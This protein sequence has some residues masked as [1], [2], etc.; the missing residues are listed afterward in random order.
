MT[1]RIITVAF[2]LQVA[3]TGIDGGAL[4]QNDTSTAPLMAQGTLAD[5]VLGQS[6]DTAFTEAGLDGGG[7]GSVN[8]LA[9]IGDYLFVGDQNNN[10][11]LG[12]NTATLTK[13]LSSADNGT[14]A[15]L[16]INQRDLVSTDYS[17]LPLDHQFTPRTLASDPENRLYV[18]TTDNEVFVYNDPI[19]TDLL[20]DYE[21][22]GLPAN[23]QSIKPLSTGRIAVVG[24]NDIK[25]YTRGV[26][27]PL[28]QFVFT[29][30]CAGSTMTD[31]E[32]VIRSGGLYY[33]LVACTGGALCDDDTH[34]CD[35]IG[36]GA[37]TG[38][39]PCGDEEQLCTGVYAYDIDPDSG[40]PT[41]TPEIVYTEFDHTVQQAHYLTLTYINTTPDR[42]LISDDEAD[43]V[44]RYTTVDTHIDNVFASGHHGITKKPADAD[45][46]IGHSDSITFGCNDGSLLPDDSAVCDPKESVVDALANIM[47]LAD[48]TNNRVIGFN[49]IASDPPSLAESADLV[50]GQPDM[51]AKYANRLEAGS[52]TF[53]SRIHLKS[54]GGTTRAYI[55]DADTHRVLIYGNIEVATTGALPTHVVGQ[56]NGDDYLPNRGGA[57]SESSI[58]FPIGVTTSRDGQSLFVADFNNRRVLEYANILDTDPTTAK[59]ATAVY[60]QV[61]FATVDVARPRPRHVAA[62]NSVLYVAMADVGAGSQAHRVFVYDTKAPSLAPTCVFGQADSVT[63]TPNRGGP[64]GPDTFKDIA[65]LHL[66]ATGSLWVSDRGNNRVLVFDN[67]ICTSIDGGIADAVVGQTNFT[68]TDELSLASPDDHMLHT[69]VGIGVN[70]ADGTLWVADQGAHRI[71]GFT[72]PRSVDPELGMPR[73]TLVLGQDDFESV[74]ASTSTTI[75][76]HNVKSPID[77]GSFGKTVAVVDNGNIRVLRYTD[78]RAPVISGGGTFE[79]LA[80]TTR[81]VTLTA[82][83]PDGDAVTITVLEDMSDI[84]SNPVI[85]FSAVDRDPG[86]EERY[87]VV[88][89]DSGGRNS[90]TTVRFVVVASDS[91]SVTVGTP[92]T[93]PS[94]VNPSGREERRAALDDSGCNAGGAP[95]LVWFGVVAL[96]R[97]R[98]G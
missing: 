72:Q 28:Q 13:P 11:I 44:M 22:S 75:G 70:D 20:W 87:T 52:M 10:R 32:E 68:A 12:F 88:A 86:Y 69:P 7:F 30:P 51:N 33:L 17:G 59:T 21:L 73:A 36:G 48:V 65:D 40:F 71:I 95:F 49:D 5:A 1:Y 89:Q 61:D 9:R 29:N 46:I 91:S 4:H 50:L 60:N 3:C 54:L 76:P 16:V 81:D 85:S 23:I 37:G 64:V 96:L 98:R 47:W 39:L 84:T 14:A 56:S 63:N 42:L 74:A 90:T 6:S 26:T 25:F 8:G 27:S 83:D 93:G 94:P 79:V 35:G 53:P 18:V 67:P 77:V 2:I 78:N 80:G 31:A 92:A 58:D 66:D 62:S 34:T 57:P 97:R 15:T 38:A 43:R 55:S 19:G 24:L 82:T 41:G 45:A